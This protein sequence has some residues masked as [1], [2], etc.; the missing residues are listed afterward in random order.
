MV[1][2][3]KVE[4]EFASCICT[5][6]HNGKANVMIIDNVVVDE[7]KRAMGYGKKLM[8]RALE[9]AEEEDVDSVEL[10]V[11]RDNEPAKK[12]YE[13]QGFAKTDKDYY[14]KILHWRI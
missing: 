11:K 6:Y 5:F 7:D 10:A 8:R 2:Q 9:L 4:T 12:L 13:G 1:N 3:V 14:R